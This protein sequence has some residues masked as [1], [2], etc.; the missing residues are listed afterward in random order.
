MGKEQ[1][2]YPKNPGIRPKDESPIK[3]YSKIG[4]DWN[5]KKILFLPI[6]YGFKFDPLSRKNNSI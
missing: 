4:W 2:S 3:S 5:P 1:L 6:G